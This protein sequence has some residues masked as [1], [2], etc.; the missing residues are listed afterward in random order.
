MASVTKPQLLDRVAG[1]AGAEKSR[2]DAVL[3]AFFETVVDEGRKGNKVGFPGFGTF[4]VVNRKARTGRNPQTGGQVKIPA[5]KAM[6]FSPSSTLKSSL[7]GKAK[8]A[9]ARKSTR[10]R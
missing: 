7:Q 4:S 5:S 1:K 2:V 6:K 10:K 3:V 9:A 8:K